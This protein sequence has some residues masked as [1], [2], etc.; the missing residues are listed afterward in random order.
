MLIMLISLLLALLVGAGVMLLFDKNNLNVL[1]II[2][3]ISQIFTFMLPSF[4]F[5]KINKI[6][7]KDFW[8]MNTSLSWKTILIS[9]GLLAAAIPFIDWLVVVNSKLVLPEWMNGI[10]N[11][12]RNKQV[13]NEEIMTRLL[14]VNNIGGLLFNILIIAI[15]PAIGEEFLFRGVLQKMLVNKMRSHHW[16]IFITSIVF[17]AAHMEFYSFLPRVI[18]GMILGYTFYYSGSIIVPIILH[19][20]NNTFSITAFYYYYNYIY[21]GETF[22]INTSSEYTN[23]YIACIS[24]AGSLLILY[25][26]KRSITNKA[27][28]LYE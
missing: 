27:K 21:N 25:L 18:L 15:I 14:S 7:I 6:E 12:M 20:L 2:Q 9:I 17:S 4:I 3:G 26:L 8:G 10:D 28:N 23:I 24:L 1:K 16:A 19:F 11:W 13:E 5:L 22:D